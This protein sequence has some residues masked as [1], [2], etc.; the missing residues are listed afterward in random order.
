MTA[1]PSH[2]RS[3]VRNRE[4]ARRD[5]TPHVGPARSLGTLMF[6][7]VLAIFCAEVLVMLVLALLPEMQPHQEALVDSALLIVLLIPAF[8]YL[9]YLPLQRQIGELRAAQEALSVSEQRFSDVA[10]HVGEWIWEVDA[11]GRYTYS[12]PM[13]EEILGYRSEEVLG[14][15]FYDFFLDEEREELKA[16]A[17]QVFAGKQSFNAF[18]NRNRHRDGRVVTLETSGLPLLDAQ[19]RLTGYRGAD[20]DIT[21]RVATQQRLVAAKAE[22][23]EA[24]RAKSTFLA[25]MSHEL[26]TPLNGVLGMLELLGDGRLD[27][28]QREQLGLASESGRRLL[29]L[30]D[31]LL[32][33]SRL[34]SDQLPLRTQ[35]FDPHELVGSVAATMRQAAENKGLRFE[36]HC[37]RLMPH[38]LIGDPGHI[39]AVLEHLT[40][41]AIKFTHQGHVRIEADYQASGEHAGTLHL[42][43]LDTGIGLPEGPLERLF[44][45]FTQAEDHAARRFGGTGLGLALCR[46]L[47]ETMQGRIGAERR[48]S[49]G[50]LFWVSL[51]LAHAEEA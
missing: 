16:A 32:E 6:A 48:A 7:I 22:A 41:N 11:D 46:R 24:N 44:A 17:F 51:P 40:N 30:I 21:N 10:V 18:L 12:S 5:P 31:Q 9:I 34:E 19:G 4:D 26:R 42:N 29:R 2:A 20:R 50:A 45:E 38:R 15:H 23:E 27:A 43:V 33:Y 49:G 13:V 25:N 3:V 47:V 8:Y 36:V 28:A 37:N 14:K 35:T 1:E 39:G